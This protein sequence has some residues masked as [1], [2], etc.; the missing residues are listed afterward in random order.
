MKIARHR[1]FISL[2]RSTKLLWLIWQETSSPKE[3]TRCAVM[4]RETRRR[5][6]LG[7]QSHPDS[8]LPV[9]LGNS[10]HLIHTHIN[11]VQ[12]RSIFRWERNSQHVFNASGPNNK[13]VCSCTS[14]V[15]VDPTHSCLFFNKVG[16]W[17][18]MTADENYISP[19]I[20]REIALK[21][22]L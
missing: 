13:R 10:F 1:P 18:Q 8:L 20:A 16:W 9:H 3:V 14:G 2:Q 6:V 12:Q 15:V 11:F 19:I 21:N 5:R 22:I 4:W 17:R 7:A